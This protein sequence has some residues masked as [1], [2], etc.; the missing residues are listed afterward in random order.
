MAII[1]VIAV[2]AVMAMAVVPAV[3]AGLSS[4]YPNVAAR[5]S[6]LAALS[7]PKRAREARACA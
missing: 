2:M 5:S 4:G 7:A 1:A 6:N 3:I